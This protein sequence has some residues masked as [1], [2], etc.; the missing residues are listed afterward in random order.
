MNKPSLSLIAL[1]LSAAYALHAAPI[2]RCHSFLVNPSTGP[3]AEITVSSAE[4]WSGTLTVT[5][6]DGWTID[7]QAH[8][9]TL[10][11]NENKCL[12]YR[13]IKAREVADNAYPFTLALSGGVTVTQTVRT[14][15]APFGKPKVDGKLDDWKDAIPLRFGEKGA[16]TTLRTYWDNAAFYLAIEVEQK[17]LNLSRTDGLRNAVQLY[18]APK[19]ATVKRHEFLIEPV[20][21][22]KAICKRLAS[23][24]KVNDPDGIEEKGANVALRTSGG[25]TVYEIALPLSLLDGIRVDAGREFRLGLLVHDPDGSGLRDLGSI[26][27]RPPDSRTSTPSC[28][29]IW[30]GGCWNTPFYDGGTEFGFC[31]SI[32]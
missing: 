4:A 8:D 13:I 18:L 28:F 1:S 24:D 19:S 21:K 29:F 17:T 12:P 6:P 14:A 22:S 10:Q 26:M 9:I 27:N 20:S 32:H 31:S 11:A 30:K 2:M 25:V 15:S 16:Q 7:P 3:V 23:P 5:P